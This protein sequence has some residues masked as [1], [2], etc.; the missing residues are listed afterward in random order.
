MADAN[1]R[2][3]FQLVKL[4]KLFKSLMQTTRIDVVMS[5]FEC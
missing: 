3:R 1:P 2:L 4:V 5:V